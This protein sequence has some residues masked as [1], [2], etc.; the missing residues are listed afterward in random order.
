MTLWFYRRQKKNSSPTEDEAPTDL[1]EP[2]PTMVMDEETREKMDLQKNLLECKEEIQEL[3]E[4]LNK[5]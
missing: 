3:K 2:V 4:E 1:S 5:D